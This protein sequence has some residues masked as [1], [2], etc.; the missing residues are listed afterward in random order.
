M[1]SDVEKARV[2]C[3]VGIGK[4]SASDSLLTCRNRYRWHRNR[5]VYKIPGGVWRV[6]ADWPGGV[7]HGGDASP[8][9]GF[10]MER[11]QARVTGKVAEFVSCCATT[12]SAMSGLNG[13]G[14]FRSWSAPDAAGSFSP[15]VPEM[16]TVAIAVCRS[17]LS[18]PTSGIAR[19]SIAATPRHL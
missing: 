11:E 12:Y 7:R 8:V 15:R 18:F 9:C 17:D 10:C 13:V 14:T 19:S 1:V 5:G 16:H 6:P 4:A 3:Q 2:T